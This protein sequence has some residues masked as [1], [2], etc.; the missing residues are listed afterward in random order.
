VRAVAPVTAFGHAQPTFLLQK[1]Q[2]DNLS[3]EFLGEVGGA[4]FLGGEFSTDG[5][6]LFGEV[7]EFVFEVEEQRLVLFEEFLGDGLHA[8]G[9]LDLRQRWMILCVLEQIEKTTLR[10]VAAFAF[11]D[12][13]GT[14]A[15]RGKLGLHTHLAVV[16]LDGDVF[17]FDVGKTPLLFRGRHERNEGGLLAVLGFEMIG[18][19]IADGGAGTL[20]FGFR[21]QMDNNY[22]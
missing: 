12:N 10:R 18:D 2:E 21:R 14:A 15:R 16:L 17:H 3:H 22:V 5:L 1:V 19:E 6:V 4:D 13:V 7:V 20:Q 9:V 8:E 11:A